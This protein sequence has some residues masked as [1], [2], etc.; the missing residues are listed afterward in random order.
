[1]ELRGS[2]TYTYSAE[3]K[4]SFLELGGGGEDEL[5]GGEGGK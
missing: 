1:M 5:G 4:P 3:A 2:D